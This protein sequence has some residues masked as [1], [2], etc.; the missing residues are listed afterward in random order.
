MKIPEIIRCHINFYCPE[1]KTEMNTVGLFDEVLWCNKC[2]QAYLLKLIKSK[3]TKKDLQ[4]VVGF[5]K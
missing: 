5:P 2:Q 1:C 4:D 3:L